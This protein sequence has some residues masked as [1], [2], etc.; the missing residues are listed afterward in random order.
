MSMTMVAPGNQRVRASGVHVYV[1]LGGSTEQV[2]RALQSPVCD[3]AWGLMP[4]SLR[5]LICKWG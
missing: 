3:L 4:L 2:G 5:L 1:W